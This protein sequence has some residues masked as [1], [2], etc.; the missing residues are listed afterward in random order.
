MEVLASQVYCKGKTTWDSSWRRN[1][2]GMIIKARNPS[3]PVFQFKVE[4]VVLPSLN[5]WGS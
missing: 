2:H 4:E 1:V 3:T 5:A